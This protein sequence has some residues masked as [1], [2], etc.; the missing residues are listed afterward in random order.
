MKLNEG[1]VYMYFITKRE[2]CIELRYWTNRL[3]SER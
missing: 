3:Y 2:M 1:P